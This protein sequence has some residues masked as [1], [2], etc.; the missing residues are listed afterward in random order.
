MGVAVAEK[1]DVECDMNVAEP[2]TKRVVGRPFKK[3]NPG[4]PKGI[5]DKSF[6][7]KQAIL[8]AVNKVADEK[9]M[10]M[11]EYLASMCR[12]KGMDF[13]KV[14]TS[15]LPKE[16]KI[17]LVQRSSDAFG[18]ELRAMSDEELARLGRVVE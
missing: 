7:L 8:G 13:L 16:Q 3:G 15:L 17:D 11:E 12:D 1:T 2:Q 6:R 9:G 10:S 14:A 18:D 5:K 4:R